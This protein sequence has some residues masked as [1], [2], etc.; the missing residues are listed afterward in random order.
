MPNKPV[1]DIIYRVSAVPHYTKHV[2]ETPIEAFFGIGLGKATE[3]NLP[4]G[5]I[6]FTKY[7]YLNYNWFSFQNL[8]LQTGWVGIT[9]YVSFFFSLLIYNLYQKYSAPVRYRYL[10]DITITIALI[11]ILVI[12]YN[13]TL[14][15][16]YAIV[17][18]FVLGLGPCVTRELK[19]QQIKRRRK[20]NFI[21]LSR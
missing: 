14:R 16:S 19:I 12:W 7:Q 15:L 11:C 5:H 18:Y 13:A 1:G 20:D 6:F 4:F 10:Y 3:A 21:N 17:P 9:L 8:F 2:F